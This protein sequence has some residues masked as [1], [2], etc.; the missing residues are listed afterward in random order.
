MMLK[1]TDWVGNYSRFSYDEAKQYFYVLK[2]QGV[3]LLDDEI[4]F[5]QE[6]NI[7]FIRRLISSLIGDGSADSGFKIDGT[8]AT[9]D[10]TIKA[11]NLVRDGWLVNLAS[12]TTYGAQPQ[13]QA[14]LTTPSGSNRTDEVYIDFW[15]E[16]IDNVEDSNIVDP[17]LTTRTSCRLQLTWAVKVA[18][19]STVPV[20]YTDGQNK[21]HW[22][23]KLATLNRLDA[24][25]TITASMVVEERAIAPHNKAIATATTAITL[26]RGHHILLCNSGTA[27]NVTLPIESDIAGN[28]YSKEYDIRNLGTGVVTVVGT[29]DGVTDPTLAQNET[30][31]IYTE[32]S[33]YRKKVVTHDHSN[34]IEGG[35]VLDTPTIADFTNAIHDHGDSNDGGA[36]ANESITG[37]KINTV[38]VM[39]TSSFGAGGIGYFADLSQWVASASGVFVELWDGSAWR[40]SLVEINGGISICNPTYMR[41]YFTN[42]TTLYS[43]TF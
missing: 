23:L 31:K 33:G 1:G 6:A 22:I 4:N 35:N 27:F 24:D 2:E 42:A 43:H 21:Y 20:E 29:I 39:S 18:E 38:P 9:N 40:R 41:L 3:P 5:L 13:S 34:A 12:D 36:L 26:T 16:E 11:G 28:G 37:S 19:G 8:G 25:A 17:V 10:F 30:L 14:A 7:T 15:F 32:G